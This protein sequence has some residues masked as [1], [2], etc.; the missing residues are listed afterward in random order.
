MIQRFTLAVVTLSVAAGAAASV[1]AIETISVTPSGSVGN[2]GAGNSALSADGRFVVFEAGASN[3]VVAP[4]TCCG[5][6]YLRDRQTQTTELISKSTD[7]VTGGG[8]GR[9]FASDVTPD[10]RYVVY[11]SRATNLVEGDGSDNLDVFLRDREAGT[12]ERISVSAEGGDADGDSR[13][14]YIS[15]DGRFVA[16]GSDATNLVADGF[17]VSGRSDVYVRDR[18]RGT[19][20]R[21]SRALSGAPDGAAMQPS[22]SADG[23]VVAFESDASNLVA[24]DRNALRDV[25]VYDRATQRTELVSVTTTGRQGKGDSSRARIS[26]DGRFVAFQSDAVNF[27]LKLTNSQIAV[28]LRD[29][30]LNRLEPVSLTA[31]GKL[32]DASSYAPVVS[33]SGRFVAFHCDSPSLASPPSGHLQVYVRDRQARTTQRASATASGAGLEDDAGNAS[34]SR[35]GRTVAF[36]SWSAQLAPNDTNYGFDVFVASMSYPDDA[37]VPVADA[38]PD[39][40]VT[41]TGRRTRVVLDA[42]ASTDPARSP[43][44][45]AW[46]ENGRRIASGPHPSVKFAVGVHSV[47]LVATDKRRLVGADEVLVSVAQ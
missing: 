29:R 36:G 4:T 24:N 2:A 6:V 31:A 7:G 37:P 33:A 42:S 38:G 10:G 25:F 18:Q 20:E 39:R 35:D 13:D 8:G 30:A 14:C 27:G 47:W 17:S 44:K 41:G 28:F 23:R 43:L 22:I 45:F 32:P 12:T 15:D 21:V 11:Y 40:S 26:A 9:S 34:L 3:L 46:F 19:T 1:T 5:Q 16:F